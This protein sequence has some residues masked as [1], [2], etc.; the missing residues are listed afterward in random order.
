MRYLNGA[1]T[2]PE[3][4]AE[5]LAL[6]RLRPPCVPQTI[7][8][9]CHH[10]KVALPGEESQRVVR[11]NLCEECDQVVDP[12]LHADRCVFDP[13]R[14]ALAWNDPWGSDWYERFGHPSTWWQRPEHEVVEVHG[15]LYFAEQVGRDADTWAP[16]PKVVDGATPPRGWERLLDWPMEHWPLDAWIRPAPEHALAW[17]DEVLRTNHDPTDDAPLE[18]VLVEWADGFWRPHLARCVGIDPGSGVA[19]V[20]VFDLWKDPEIIDRTNLRVLLGRQDPGAALVNAVLGIKE[21]RGGFSGL[22]DEG[23]EA[24]LQILMLRM[25]GVYRPRD[26][27]R[28]LLDSWSRT[29]T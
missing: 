14:E 3:E 25:T 29:D 15:S 7:S 6:V 18:Y 27:A 4:H 10:L 22:D 11:L 28:R 5:P 26:A 24:V 17:L 16:L 21:A 12:T 8:L 19:S 2:T 13:T 20:N 23:M 9:K 1:I